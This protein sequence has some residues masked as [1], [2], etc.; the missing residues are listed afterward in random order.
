VPELEQK[1]HEMPYLPDPYSDRYSNQLEPDNGCRPLCMPE[2]EPKF[3][4]MP[5]LSSSYFHLDSNH[6]KPNTVTIPELE[7]NFDEM[8]YLP[9]P[10]SDRTNNQFKPDAITSSDLC[11]NGATKFINNCKLTA[12]NW[13]IKINQIRR[14]RKNA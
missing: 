2:L 5:E 8:P 10:Y 7:P 1:C 6:F 11:T 9:D 3:H 14:H 4:E 12:F 13:K